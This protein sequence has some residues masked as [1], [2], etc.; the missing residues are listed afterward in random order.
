MHRD[1]NAALRFIIGT[2]VAAGLLLFFIW[3]IHI[4]NKGLQSPSKSYLERKLA[5]QHETYQQLEFNLVDPAQA[6]KDI[7]SMARLGYN[8]IVDTQTNAKEYCGNTLNCTNCHFAG[9][10]TTGGAQGGISLAGAA[11]RYPMYDVRLQRVIDL[12]QRINNCFTRS[13]NGTAVPHD[14]ELML[15]MVTYLQWISKNLPIYKPVPWLGLKPLQKQREGDPEQG[16]RL[17][18]VYCALCH[19]DNGEGGDDV[20]A[21]WGDGS[22]NDEAG[23]NRQGTMASFIYWNMPYMD[24]TPV[25]SEEQAQDVAAYIIEQPRPK[26]ERSQ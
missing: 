15:A 19:R 16:K 7:R 3:L 10:N 25:L 17:Y 2:F 22:F 5:R 6:P 4:G 24:L 26:K 12:E 21:L 9:G 23:M 18:N 14:S 20:P 8:I 11:T 13:M 1:I